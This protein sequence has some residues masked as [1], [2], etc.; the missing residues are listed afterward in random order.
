MKFYLCKF[1]KFG[2]LNVNNIFFGGQL[3]K[4]I[5]EEVGIYVMFKFGN[6]CV[7]IKYIFEIDFVSLGK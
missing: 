5:D 1:I 4:W 3:L 7:V 6:K 2:D